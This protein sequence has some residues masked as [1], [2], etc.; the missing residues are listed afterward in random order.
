MELRHL[1]YFVAVGDTLSYTRA[2]ERLHLTQPSLTRQVKDLEGELGVRLLDRTKQRVNLTVEGRSFLNDAKRI[3]ALSEE[4]VESVRSLGRREAPALNVGYVADLFYD[5]LPTTLASFQSAC[6]TISVNLFDMS[7]GDQFRALHDGKIDLGFVGLREAVEEAG[8]EFRSIASYKT[9]VALPKNNR[10]ANQRVIKLKD[11]ES[12][13]FIG[14]SETSYPGYRRWLTQTC[15]RTGFTPRVLQDVEIERTIIQ[16]VGA[17]LGIALVP[18]Q[19][20]KVPHTNV[21]F[22]PV[23]PTVMT[24][25]CIAWKADNSCTAMRAC[26]DILSALGTSM[27]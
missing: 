16:S 3:L 2:S 27:R 24:E 6:P 10:M 14:M 22:R 25:S 7:C 13:F 8:L 17:G 21:V 18:D 19:M 12:F 26:I 5:F 20:R 1:R 15:R 23:T 11:L 9:V 4:I